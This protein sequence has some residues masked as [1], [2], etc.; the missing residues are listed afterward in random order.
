M[1]NTE[2]SLDL[3]IKCLS[4]DDMKQRFIKSILGSSNVSLTDKEFDILF[5]LAK[6]CNGV[7]STETRKQVCKLLE[8][9]IGNLNNNI[10]RMSEKGVFVELQDK[11]TIYPVFMIDLHKLGFLKLSFTHDK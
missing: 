11:T 9:S 6:H 3:K 10:S 7:L 2:Q 1:S 8:I 4:E 5:A